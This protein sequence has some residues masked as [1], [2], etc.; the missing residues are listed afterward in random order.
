VEISVQSLN[1]KDEQAEGSTSP[2]QILFIVVVN[3]GKVVV[4]EG[5]HVSHSTGH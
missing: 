4:M 1:V 5:I 3:S 2:L